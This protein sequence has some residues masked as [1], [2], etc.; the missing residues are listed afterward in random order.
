MSLGDAEQIKVPYRTRD[1]SMSKAYID[2]DTGEGIDKHSG[3]PP[4]S[5]TLAYVQRIRALYPFDRHPY[6][7]T[8]SNSFSKAAAQP[9]RTVDA[10]AVVAGDGALAKN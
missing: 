10:N 4:F 7:A 5:E 8:I 1:G 3:V 2:P 6:D 9:T